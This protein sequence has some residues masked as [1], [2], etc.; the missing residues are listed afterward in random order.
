MFLLTTA[1][2][3]IGKARRVEARVFAERLK[4]RNS[5]GCGSRICAHHPLLPRLTSVLFYKQNMN[6]SL[7][8]YFL[9]FYFIE[10]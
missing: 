5:A 3:V 10:S 6:L 7:S 9:M 2:L 8:C 4:S 1:R